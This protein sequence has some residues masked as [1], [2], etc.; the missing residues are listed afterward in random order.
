MSWWAEVLAT[1][2]FFKR[3]LLAGGVLHRYLL[4]SGVAF[5]PVAVLQGSTLAAVQNLH[6]PKWLDGIRLQST[7]PRRTAPSLPL[8][9]LH[10]KNLLL[11]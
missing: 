2:A 8:W 6:T 7:T 10:R 4:F 11:A 1:K 3:P 5:R 9:A